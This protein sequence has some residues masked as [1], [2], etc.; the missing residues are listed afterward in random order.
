MF[1][2]VVCLYLD[3]CFKLFKAFIFIF[4]RYIKFRCVLIIGYGFVINACHISANDYP[5]TCNMCV[6]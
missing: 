1:E 6:E 2:V 5:F 3:I 4:P